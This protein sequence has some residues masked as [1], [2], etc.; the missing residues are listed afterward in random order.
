VYKKYD[1]GL[2]QVIVVFKGRVIFQTMV[3]IPKKHKH[4]SM[5]VYRFCDSSGYTHEMKLYLGKD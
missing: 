1:I 2:T 4:I 3:Y 5:K